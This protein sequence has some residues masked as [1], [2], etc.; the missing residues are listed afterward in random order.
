[1]GHEQRNPTCFP[2]T[3][4]PDAIIIF[5]KMESPPYL[6]YWSGLTR[7]VGA[8]RRHFL[9]FFS[10]MPRRWQPV[11]AVS[12]SWPHTSLA[13]IGWHALSAAVAVVHGGAYTAVTALRTPYS[14]F[15]LYA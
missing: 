4:T 2:T 8:Q 14:R 10:Q 9:P 12:E 15:S 1:M 7:R 6:S 13:A 5:V 3:T 11:R